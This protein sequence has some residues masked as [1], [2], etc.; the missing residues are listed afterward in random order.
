MVINDNDVDKDHD[1]LIEINNLDDLN[2]IRNNLEGKALYGRSDGCPL[3]GCFGFE[4]T[5]HLDFDANNNGVFDETDPYWNNGT[6][7]QPIGAFDSIK[8]QDF[9]AVFEG[10]G[11]TISH[12]SLLGQQPAYLYNGLFSGTEGATIRNL[13][14]ADVNVTKGIVNAGLAGTIKNSTVIGCYV[15]GIVEGTLGAEAG[16]TASLSSSLIE[17]SYVHM[18]SS[19]LAAAS[20]SGFVGRISDSTIRASYAVLDVANN[21]SELLYFRMGNVESYTN[22]NYV[23]YRTLQS[24]KTADQGFAAFNQQLETLRC[25][26]GP[27]NTTCGATA[28]YEHWGEYIDENGHPYWNFG[29]ENDLPILNYQV[30]APRD[31]DADGALDINDAFPLHYEAA[32]DADGDGA[33]GSNEWSPLCEDNCQLESPLVT[34]QFP[35]VSAVIVDAD[36]DGLADEW[37]PTCDLA[38]Q[39]NSQLNLDPFI[40]DYDNDGLTTAEDSDDNNDNIEDADSD[41]D[42]L[43]EVASWQALNAIRYSLSGHGR[44]WATDDEL[45]SSGCPTQIINGKIIHQCWGYELTADLDFDTNQDGTLNDQDAYWN[46]GQ[47]WLPLGNNSGFKGTFEGNGHLIRNLMINRPTPNINVSLFGLL[48]Y[49]QIRNMGFTGTLMSING[50]S[51]AILADKGAG[52]VSGVFA[53]GGSHDGLITN[54]S[55]RKISIT[56]SFVTGATNR[57]SH[58]DGRL[59]SD[60]RITSSF[61]AQRYGA[62][63]KVIQPAEVNY[64]GVT[65]APQEPANQYQ[66]TRAQLACRTNENS[67]Q[68]TDAPHILA[69]P[70]VDTDAG[71]AYWD[72]GTSA[73]LPGLHIGGQLYRDGDGDGI[74]DRDDALPNIHGASVDSDGDGSPEK[75]HESCDGTCAAGLV[76]DA[77][78]TMP[79]ASVDNDLDGM[80]DSWNSHCD[81][82]CQQA[83]VLTLDPAPNDVDNDGITDALDDDDNNDGLV[84][85][86][87]NSNGL[88]DIYTL[89]QLDNVRFNLSGHGLQISDS[90]LADSSGCPPAIINGKL[91]PL[92]RGYELMN[93]LDFDTNKDHIIDSADAYWRDG[94]GWQP[95]GSKLLDQP[96]SATFDGNGF[97]LFN[98]HIN[99]NDTIDPAKM[100]AQAGLFSFIRQAE[101]RNI[102][103]AGKLTVISGSNNTGGLVSYAENSVIKRCDITGA[104]FYSGQYTPANL[105]TS[106]GGLIGEMRTSLVEASA[107][108]VTILGPN[109]AGIVGLA[110]NSVIKS[111]YSLGTL[112]PL[113]GLNIPAGLLGLGQDSSIVNSYSASNANYY[114]ITRP[115]KTPGSFTTK[116][117]ATVI[118]SYWL[119]DD[120]YPY[121]PA[122]QSKG[123]KVSLAELQCPTMAD[124]TNCSTI[125]LF[126]NWQADLDEWGQPYWDF[127]DNTSLPRLSFQQDSGFHSREN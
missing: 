115:D 102:H 1:G 125:T 26:T 98:L 25:P 72:F 28:L 49:A 23:A 108:N 43:I 121:S 70:S 66:A 41:S 124:N 85:I 18:R 75:L 83:S 107:T 58:L 76:V 47:G 91:K 74:L 99:R 9:K 88:I 12:L 112:T 38:C 89:E 54:D 57:I 40:D 59:N 71:D 93:D 84:D 16:I 117:N 34:D 104:I 78:P 61:E 80:P 77:F 87:S 73:Q 27:D 35:L 106:M 44:R 2:E 103:I 119:V 56:T 65:N 13:G 29:T 50:Y 10:N 5:E 7:W 4:L 94:L 90:S 126:K 21:N 45:D 111:S 64:W 123:Q 36:I 55:Y 60:G 17:A 113:A 33:P 68:C 15:T 67:D 62:A 48:S 100:D 19:T 46:D 101:L 31:N 52:S 8:S 81:N 3:D 14:L 86:D 30:T 63:P 53:A 32:L 20:Q 79:E 127:G 24:N 42:G 110:F 118:D 92:C 39:Q 51:S 96:F 82:N 11:H 37:A 114:G 122:A 109:P 116:I 22:D 6:G 97:T 95:I 120:T 69:W 105:L